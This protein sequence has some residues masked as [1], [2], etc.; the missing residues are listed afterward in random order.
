MPQ[1]IMPPEGV[2]YPVLPVGPKQAWS[3]VPLQQVAMPAHT[4]S[5]DLTDRQHSQ[6]PAQ[7]Q[8][9]Q[10]VEQ[11]PARQAMTE[12]HSGL[13]VTCEPI[14]SECQACAECC[15]CV[16]VSL[17][18]ISVGVWACECSV[19]TAEGIAIAGGSTVGAS[20]LASLVKDCAFVPCCTWK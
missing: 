14:T 6:P 12:A 18:A 11:A 4:P 7:T 16:G 10:P 5:M 3:E 15:A 13:T 1:T 19:A 9:R 17:L 20:L 8:P 2:A